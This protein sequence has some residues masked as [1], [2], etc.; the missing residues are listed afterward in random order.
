[1]NGHKSKMK[2]EL[3]ATPPDKL[4]ELYDE[5]FKGYSSRVG[6]TNSTSPESQEWVNEN[7]D[8]RRFLEVGAGYGWLAD[9]L[10]REAPLLYAGKIFVTDFSIQAC[11]TMKGVGLH[12]ICCDAQR[13]PFLDL[14]FDTVVCSHVLEHVVD[15]E[16]ALSELIRVSR[17]RVLIIVPDYV[18][19]DGNQDY[20]LRSYPDI[21]E[22]DKLVY[23]VCPTLTVRYSHVGSEVRCV[24]ETQP[25]ETQ[26]VEM[27]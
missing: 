11:M 21:R 7:L 13:L 18:T 17:N 12:P 5:Y 9:Y 26:E 22:L 6:W 23:A 3:E 8:G 14:S 24:L 19:H 20:H 2:Q 1:M 27:T 4:H 16:R 15:P 10:T 25:K